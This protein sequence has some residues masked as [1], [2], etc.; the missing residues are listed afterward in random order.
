MTVVRETSRPPGKRLV[1]TRPPKMATVP[2]E[3][4][5]LYPRDTGLSMTVWVSPRGRAR[6]D[7]WIGVHRL[8]GDRTSSVRP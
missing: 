3:M 6:H 8:R 7:I 4:A 5:S 1:E 2:N